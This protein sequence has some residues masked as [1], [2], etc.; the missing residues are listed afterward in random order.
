MADLEILILLYDPMIWIL[1]S[2]TT[3]LVLVEFSI[4]NL[5]FPPWP[6]TRPI[7]RER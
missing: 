7:A 5:V 6:A 3:I 4:V 1:V 2:A